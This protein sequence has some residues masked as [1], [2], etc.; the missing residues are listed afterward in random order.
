MK[1][2]TRVCRSLEHERVLFCAA[3]GVLSASI[4]SGSTRYLT[5]S[6]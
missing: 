3:A 6:L 1:Q 2:A 4:T 5:G